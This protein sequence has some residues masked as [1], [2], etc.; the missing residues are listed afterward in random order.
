MSHSSRSANSMHIV[1]STSW[2]R[3]LHDPIYI[4]HIK[5]SRCHI[6]ESNKDIKNV[7]LKMNKIIN[8]HIQYKLKAQNRFGSI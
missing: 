2:R 1:E 8:S 3:E 4:R 7:N 5:A 6:L